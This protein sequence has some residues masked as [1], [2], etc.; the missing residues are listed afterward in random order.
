MTVENRL[1]YFARISLS[2]IEENGLYYLLIS[3]TV[4]PDIS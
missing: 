4:F 2:L 3:E 1:S